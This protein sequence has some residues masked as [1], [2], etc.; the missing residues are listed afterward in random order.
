M[1]TEHFEASSN[2]TLVQKAK[3]YCL[4]KIS[5]KTK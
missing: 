2:V 1:L 3:V 4:Y 5:K